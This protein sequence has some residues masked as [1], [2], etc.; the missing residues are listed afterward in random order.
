MNYEVIVI[1]VFG[2][3]GEMFYGFFCYYR[4]GSLIIGLKMYDVCVIVYLI[5]LE[6]FEIIEMFIEVVLEGLVVGVIVVDLKMKYYKNMNVVVCID[7][8][9]EVF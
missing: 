4:G 2:R 6:L 3:V 5:L 7:V 8:N 9:V 1:R